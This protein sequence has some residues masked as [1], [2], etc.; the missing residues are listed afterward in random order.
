MPLTVWAVIF[1]S[2]NFACQSSTNNSSTKSRGNEGA[3]VLEPP[4]AEEEQGYSIWFKKYREGVDFY[5]M[6]SEPDWTLSMDF[7]KNFHFHTLAETGE[8]Y[9][10]SVEPAQAQDAPVRRYRAEV[11]AGEMIIR[12][13]EE[14]CTNPMSG[15]VFPFLVTVDIKRGRDP[16]FTTFK[17][18]GR[19]VPDFRLTDIWVLESLY[20]DPVKQE[21][22]QKGLPRIELN[23]EERNLLGHD[24]C[25]SLRGSLEAG[26]G[27]WRMGPLMGTLMACPDMEDPDRVRTSLEAS[28]YEIANNRLTLRKGPQI[29]SVWRKVD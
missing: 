20:G 27:I 14:A 12:L 18:C 25:N 4:A 3:S 16:D 9:V 7:E 23:M 5:A 6:G 8:M 21:A 22:F 29:T 24:G 26:Y 13:A 15:E 2:L 1:L 28:S 11:E 17:G 19:Y 10:P